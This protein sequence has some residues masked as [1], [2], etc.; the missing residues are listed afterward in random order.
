[1]QELLSADSIR[2]GID[3]N[4]KEAIAIIR[5]YHAFASDTPIGRVISDYKTD[6]LCFF[7]AKNGKKVAWYI[8]GEREVAVYVDN[9]QLLSQQ[10]RNINL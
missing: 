6:K 9:C 2:K 5:L 4:I 7:V 10:E 1:M 8:E 3:C